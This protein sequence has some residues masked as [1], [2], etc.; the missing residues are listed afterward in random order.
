[1]FLACGF[2]IYKQNLKVRSKILDWVPEKREAESFNQ[3][4]SLALD[5]T[6][7]LRGFFN[8][9]CVK[10]WAYYDMK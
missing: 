2:K 6:H 1:M 4:V 10:A 7:L 9:E 8:S 3:Y 5:D